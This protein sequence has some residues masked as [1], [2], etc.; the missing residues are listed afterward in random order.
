MSKKLM[1]TLLLFVVFIG[2]L[3]WGLS[4]L[5]GAIKVSNGE[6]IVYSLLL[7]GCAGYALVSIILLP[8][9]KMP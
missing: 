2:F 5:F 1:S 6:E 7:L 8:R 3:W 4:M 9:K